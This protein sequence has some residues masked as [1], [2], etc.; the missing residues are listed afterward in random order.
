MFHAWES[1]ASL[2]T[3]A[4]TDG[5]RT[6]L[7]C[8]G[9]S[10]T[11][12]KAAPP[13][14]IISPTRCGAPGIMVDVGLP[15]IHN[16]VRYNCRAFLLNRRVVL[17]RPKLILAD[18]GNYRFAAIPE[19]TSPAPVESAPHTVAQISTRFRLPRTRPPQGGPLVHRVAP[20]TPRGGLHPP[21]V[22]RPGHGPAHVPDR[23]RGARLP[24]R[25][26]R[27]GALRGARA[28]SPTQ[29]P[30]CL[31]RQSQLQVAANAVLRALIVLSKLGVDT[32]ETAPWCFLAL[33]S[34]RSCSCLS[35]RTSA[36]R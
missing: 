34:N 11:L 25:H 10:H 16:G 6:H 18:D 12:A 13:A 3:D 36:L 33:K 15:V 17:L 26:A 19:Y 35:R 9:R 14:L 7:A 31:C 2:L 27:H 1:L 21:G 29:S 8:T 30:R 20:P 5:A 28:W 24:G 4:T 32:N 22:R 23:R